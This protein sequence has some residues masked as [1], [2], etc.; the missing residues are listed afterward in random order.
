MEPC[1]VGDWTTRPYKNLGGGQSIPLARYI[2]EQVLGRP[3]K[4]GRCALHRCNNKLCIEK[5]HIYEGTYLQ[6]FYDAEDASP[7][8]VTWGAKANKEKTHCSEG[9]RFS[10]SNTYV[11]SRGWRQCKACRRIRAKAKYQSRAKVG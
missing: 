8:G 11:D 10:P 1:K 5:T 9:H 4:P 3:I 2:L 6:N 7:S